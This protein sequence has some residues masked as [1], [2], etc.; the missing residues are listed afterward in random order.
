MLVQHRI[1]NLQLLK[2]MMPLMLDLADRDGNRRLRSH[3][4]DLAAIERVAAGNCLCVNAL[5]VGTDGRTRRGLRA[6]T[7]KL[8]MTSV[9]ASVSAQHCLG[10]QRLSPQRDQALR[11]EVLR[12]QRPKPHLRRL[13]STGTGDHGAA[14]APPVDVRVDRLVRH[15]GILHAHALKNTIFNEQ[16]DQKY[17]K[18]AD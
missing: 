16:V 10:Q 6:K 13:T 9:T 11:I 14:E 12:M 5:Q 8:W 18:N 17:E 15:H 7:L 4:A 1:A 2:Q 3:T